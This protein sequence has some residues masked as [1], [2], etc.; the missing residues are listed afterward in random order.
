[1]EF[2]KRKA[3]LGTEDEAREELFSLDQIEGA[4]LIELLSNLISDN[5]SNFSYIPTSQNA[6]TDT[7]SSLQNHTPAT[8]A[9]LDAVP[10]S[11]LMQSAR[12]AAKPTRQKLPK[13]TQDA[14]PDQSASKFEEEVIDL[15]NVNNIAD[16]FL[17]SLERDGDELIFTSDN[18]IGGKETIG[19]DYDDSD[20]KEPD[21]S[22]SGGL[23]ELDDLLGMTGAGES[24]DSEQEL[25]RLLG[26]L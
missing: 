1:M 16:L 10:L 6:T 14:E 5:S 24:S 13:S 8:D 26:D 11:E 18:P 17:N 2:P 9:P 4:E 23:D 7:F 20:Y 19:F 25:R 15:N 22:K 12:F 3:T 21:A